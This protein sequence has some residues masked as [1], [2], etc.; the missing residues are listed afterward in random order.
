MIIRSRWGDVVSCFFGEDLSEVSIFRWEGDLRFRLFCDDSEF[1]CCSE[2]GN[3]WRVW[4]EL[5]T[6]AIEDSI[7]LVIVQGVMEVLIL[8]IM[9]QIVIEL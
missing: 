9:I 8:H 6:I 2:L 7:D 1:G 5:F 3:E 4:E